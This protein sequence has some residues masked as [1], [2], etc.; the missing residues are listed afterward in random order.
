M[1]TNTAEYALRAVV[2]LAKHPQQAAAAQTIGHATHVPV[3]YLQKILR[4]L[5]RAGI[6]SAQRGVGGGFA[7]AKVPTA[8]SVHSVLRATD[9][10]VDRIERCP[11]GIPGHAELCS[12]HRLL[13]QQAA[14]AEQAFASTSIADL[15]ADQAG[16]SALCE[17][18]P[19]LA[20]LTRGKTDRAARRSQPPP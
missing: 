16:A 14:S 17:T 5:A 15:V 20:K 10:A 1:I 7:L 2:Y 11:L 8:I 6:V 19:R 4:Q 13:D 3:G 18:A 9:S 12:L